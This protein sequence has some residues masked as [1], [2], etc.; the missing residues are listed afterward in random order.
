MRQVRTPGYFFRP[1]AAVLLVVFLQ[2]CTHWS[3][4]PEPKSL[5]TNPKGTV[6]L[7]MS[8]DAKS[9][10]VKHPTIVGDSIVWESPE[11]GAVHLNQVAWVEARSIDAVATGFFAIVGVT[12]ILV[13]TLRQ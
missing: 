13:K 10:V 7:T 5:A 11:H 4:V 2:G 1:V 6:R 9:R 8:G 3:P 12:F